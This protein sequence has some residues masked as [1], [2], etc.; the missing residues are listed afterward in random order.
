MLAGLRIT[1]ELEIS[2]LSICGDSQLT[3]SQ[4]E[5]VRKSPMMKA[6]VGKVRKLE[7]H[8]SSLKLEHDPRGQDAAVKE[9]SRIA[10]KGLP[11]PAGAI[12]EKLS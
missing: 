2:H 1:V 7:C 8:F 5:G 10:A 11:V 9:L 12:V 6:Y 4:A 3:A